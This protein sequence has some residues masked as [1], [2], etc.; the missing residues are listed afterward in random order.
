[1]VQG[2]ACTARRRRVAVIE[3]K[4]SSW[5]PSF[6]TICLRIGDM[7]RQRR[8][9]ST[10]SFARPCFYCSR[11][12]QHRMVVTTALAESPPAL[13]WDDVS[14]QRVL[15]NLTDNAVDASAGK[16]RINIKTLVSPSSAVTATGIMI[17]VAENVGIPAE[18]LPKIFDCSLPPNIPGKG[19]GLGLAISHEIIKTHGGTVK[20]SREVGEGTTV[21]ILCRR[22][23]MGRRAV[24]QSITVISYTIKFRVDLS[25]RSHRSCREKSQVI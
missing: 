4:S 20:V 22:C 13:F 11:F 5:S 7:H 10:I 2:P 8:S 21:Q 18:I 23:K 3:A 24:R 9:M 19:T 25:V 16:G 6:S 14:L 1:M 17:E 15:T 12:Q